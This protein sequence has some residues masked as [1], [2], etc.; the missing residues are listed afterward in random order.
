MDEDRI[1]IALLGPPQF[2]YR[3][4]QIQ[5][6]R[7]TL[8]RLF[9][10]LAC[11]EYPVNRVAV[12]DFFWPNTDEASSRKNLRE[13]ISLLRAELPE[14]DVILVQNDFIQLNPEKVW[15]DVLKFEKLSEKLRRNTELVNNALLP[16]KVYAEI[17]DALRLWRTSEFLDGVNLLDSTQFQYWVMQR[18][19]T[20]FYWR[21][22]MMEWLAY[23]YIA[24]GDLN[25]AL[26]WL[27]TALLK[28]RQ[29]TELNYLTLN[30]LKDLGYRS[31]ALHYCSLIES[32]YSEGE[33][34]IVPEVLRELIGRVR[35]DVDFR[36][37]R[38][39]IPW[40]LSGERTVDFVGNQDLIDQLTHC[41]NRGGIYQLVGEPG[42]GKTRTLKEFYTSLEI[43]PRISYYRARKDQQFIPYQTFIQGLREVVTE[44]EWQQLDLI[45]AQALY[46]LFPEIS[47][48]RPD[49]HPEELSLVL[50]LKRLIPEAIFHLISLI[51]GEKRG[52]LIVDDAQWCD[53][54]SLRTMGYLFENE[55]ARN[56]GACILTTRNDV[57]NKYIDALFSDKK[58]IQQYGKFEIQPFL[59]EQV[60]FVFYNFTSRRPSAQVVNWLLEGSGGNA[61]YL[62][63]ILNEIEQSELN[64][65]E[66]CLKKEWPISEQLAAKIK[67]RL[68]HLSDLAGQILSILAV[69]W[70]PVKVE[71]FLSL[72]IDSLIRLNDLMNE[73]LQ[74]RLI[75]LSAD[76]NMV[77]RYQFAHGVIKQYVLGKIDSTLRKSII[78]QYFT[79][80]EKIK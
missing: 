29:N 48:A 65:D 58:S 14:Q 9:S 7:R 53:E 2:S 34:D 22:L 10:Y 8:R 23:H 21:Q 43:S 4:K 73:L 27:S 13:A 62:L 45:Y 68:S 59:A 19:E 76:D 52:L 72:S 47:Q 54:E 66:L 35:A 24:I 49:I 26:Y 17:R 79:T 20:L 74:A 41:V 11:Q 67:D 77:E 3:G 44:K 1:Q 60:S 38:K 69:A 15:V 56:L 12:S 61:G 36:E 31:A 51:L 57:E 75:V 42:S 18:R 46:P 5:I 25:E 37:E 64:I 50:E 28:D 55:K 70:R 63:A 80:T 30:C 33:T 71:V 78:Q 39:S 32:I 40:D 6:K 16:E